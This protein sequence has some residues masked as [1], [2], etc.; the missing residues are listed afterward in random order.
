[1]QLAASPATLVYVRWWWHAAGLAAAVGLVAACEVGSI[2]RPAPARPPPPG[3]S[4]ST[5][6]G[7]AEV[8]RAQVPV[9]IEFA[10]R[11]LTFVDSNRGYAFY[12]RCD[13]ED[14]TPDPTC[15]ASLLATVDGGRTWSVR[16][17]PR[18]FATDQ[19]MIVSDTGTLLL[20]AEPYGWYVSADGGVSFRYTGSGLQPPAAYYLLSG[21]FQLWRSEHEPV[22]LVDYVDGHRR[23]LPTQPPLIQGATDV[24]YDESGR[25]WVAGLDGGR[26]FVSLSRDDGRTWQ[27]Q[28]VPGPSG[29]LV[30]AWLEVSPGGG[31]VWLLGQPTSTAFPRLWLFDGASWVERPAIG[32]PPRMRSVAAL[33]DGV[34]AVSEPGGGGGLVVPPRY[35]ASDWPLADANLRVLSD[36]T[37][38][39]KRAYG[40]VFL[41]AGHGLYRRWVQIVVEQT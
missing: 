15:E 34:L 19:Q 25:L 38:M 1:V 11:T 6:A 18:P 28:E 12:T 17:H 8:R 10:N 32:S 9:S 2:R 21:R 36:G 31:D 41:A 13:D 7:I 35:R 24:K 29:S 27:R 22:R 23:G 33:G 4:A 39:S 20:L 5:R 14:Q 37:L 16:Q 26:A 30:S 3:A 40:E